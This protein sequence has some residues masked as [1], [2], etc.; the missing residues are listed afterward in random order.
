MFTDWRKKIL[1]K[2][3]SVTAAELAVGGDVVKK[4]PFLTPQ[5]VRTGIG[6][7]K[8]MERECLRETCEIW[9]PE[10]GRCSI[11]AIAKLLRKRGEADG[12]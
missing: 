9:D 5:I 4:C 11:P 1:P 7:T 6:A 10:E 2:W 8:P 12:S 3:W